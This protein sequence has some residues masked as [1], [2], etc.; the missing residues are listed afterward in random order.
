[1]SDRNQIALRRLQ[2]RNP[3]ED[4]ALARGYEAWYAGPGRQ[5]DELEK[6]LLGRWLRRFPAGASVLEVGCGTGHFTR[7]MRNSGLAPTGLDVSSAMLE[8]AERADGLR[9]VRG[10]AMALPFEAGAFDLVAFIT[11]LEFVPDPGRGLDEALRVA[12]RGLLL[13]GLNRHSWLGLQCRRSGQLPW[14]AAN[15]FTVRELVAQVRSRAG[16]RLARL[17]WRTTL[18]PLPGVGSLPLPWGGFVGLL[19]ELHPPVKPRKSP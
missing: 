12:R 6:R 1:M 11:S 3:F 16:G 18:W 7:W 4:P 10:D 13:G 8:Q 5:A 9:Y 19:A 15:F 17:S 2:G 14:T